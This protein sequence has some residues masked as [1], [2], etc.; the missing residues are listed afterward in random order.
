MS[1]LL[2]VEEQVVELAQLI[3]HGPLVLVVEEQVQ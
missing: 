2:V 3:R 1:L